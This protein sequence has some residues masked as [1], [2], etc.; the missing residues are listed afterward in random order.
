[1]VKTGVVYESRDEVGGSLL[2]G[3]LASGIYMTRLRCGPL[4]GTW[5][6]VGVM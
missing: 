5:E 2:T 1:M 4:Y 6:P 3:Q